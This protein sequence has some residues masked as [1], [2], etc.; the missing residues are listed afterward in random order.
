MR[1]LDSKMADYKGLY[2][3]AHY[4]HPLAH[5]VPEF[6]L[7]YFSINW[8]DN[9]FV[10][11]TYWF[12]QK[13]FSNYQL[14]AGCTVL[15]SCDMRW[16]DEG[17]SATFET[18]QRHPHR[19]QPAEDTREVCFA[20]AIPRMNALVQCLIRHINSSWFPLQTRLHQQ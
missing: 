4:A 14:W 1:I 2:P 16:I 3:S 13:K 18:S 12:S 5:I 17:V 8:N 15:Y 11:R 7:F 9:D 20:S 19:Q 10:I 6:I